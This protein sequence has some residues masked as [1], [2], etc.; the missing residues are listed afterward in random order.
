[1]SHQVLWMPASGGHPSFPFWK[2]LPAAS[3]RP[4]L[5]CEVDVDLISDV[6]KLLEGVVVTQQ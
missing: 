6:L 4:D 1:M 2:P 3:R 5:R